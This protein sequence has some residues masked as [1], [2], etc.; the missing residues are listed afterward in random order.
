MRTAGRLATASRSGFRTESS[1]P[2]CGCGI[3]RNRVFAAGERHW[4][5]SSSWLPVRS[6]KAAS[7]LEDRTTSQSPAFATR[8]SLRP[9]RFPAGSCMPWRRLSS[10]SAP[11]CSRGRAPR[12][13]PVRR[14]PTRVS[15]PSS[16]GR[17]GTPW[18]SRRRA[19]PL[20]HRRRD[21]AARVAE[22]PVFAGGEEGVALGDGPEALLVRLLGSGGDGVSRAMAAR[23]K[24]PP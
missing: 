10:S 24:K 9:A 5:N 12:R 14:G 6:K 1:L 8:H 18:R 17:A 16:Q 3:P 21:G 20:P 11:A 4:T 15:S 22:A 19:W 2:E 13:S 7:S 23:V